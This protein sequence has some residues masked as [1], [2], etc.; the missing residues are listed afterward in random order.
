MCRLK[1]KGKK[2]RRQAAADRAKKSET[3]MMKEIVEGR[4]RIL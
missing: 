2:E 4:R 1:D 3:E